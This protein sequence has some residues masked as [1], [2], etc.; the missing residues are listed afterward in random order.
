M[1]WY[2]WLVRPDFQGPSSGGPRNF[3]EVEL[4]KDW[5]GAGVSGT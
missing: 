4:M 3:N 1:H 2:L 5:R